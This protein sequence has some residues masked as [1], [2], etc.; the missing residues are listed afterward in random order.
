MMWRSPN[1]CVSAAT[2]LANPAPRR[3]TTNSPAR[4]RSTIV[5]PARLSP[6]RPASR[7]RE[8][9]GHSSYSWGTQGSMG[10]CRGTRQ[11]RSQH[12][13]ISGRC[14]GRGGG[15]LGATLAAAGPPPLASNS[16]GSTALVPPLRLALVSASAP[17]C[18]RHTARTKALSGTRMPAQAGQ[19]HRQGR[20]RVRA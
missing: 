8:Q 11:T 7:T 16:F 20:R 1:R 10:G 6:S 19:G 14:H 18:C 15:G 3:S 13:S 4:D 12:G 9:A 5:D 2:A 17:R